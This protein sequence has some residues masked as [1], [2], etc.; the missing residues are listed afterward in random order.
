MV[1]EL[2]G[3]MQ[4]VPTGWHAQDP[5]TI[6]TRA[7]EMLGDPIATEADERGGPVY[8]YDHERER[9]ATTYAAQA[10][11][12]PLDHHLAAFLSSRGQLKA[13]TKARHERALGALSSW[14]RSN[15]LP[16][17]IEAIT[18]KVAIRYVDQLP[19]GR[20]D[21][22]RLSLY[23]QWMVRREHAPTDPWSGLQAARR[24]RVEPERARTDDEVRRLLE[25]PG[26]PALSLLMRVAALSGA[27]LDA[28]INAKV[29]DGC[30]VFPAQKKEEK[31]RRVPIHSS[32]QGVR[33]LTHWPSS[34]AASHAFTD[35]RRRVLGPDSGDRRRAVANFRSFRRW[36]ISQAERAGIDERIISDVVGHERRSMTGRY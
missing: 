2:K 34:M 8:I 27:R 25:G 36:F 10:S 21:P 16:S 5:E 26:S 13:D 35:Y 33:L 1:A 6:I 17:T 29:E 30:W 4:P 3:G 28:I 15:D 7:E 9:R 31:A 12:A 18:R 20:P 19:P 11:Q 32:L 22:Q 14:L 24:A 23:W